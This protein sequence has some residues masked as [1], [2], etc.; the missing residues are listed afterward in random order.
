MY[1]TR[2]EKNE[3][4]VYYREID[5][6]SENRL[7]LTHAYRHN[8]YKTKMHSHQFYEINI[9]SYGEGRHYI[10]DSS[11]PTSVGD[12]F[13]LPPEIF[14][15]YHT[16]GTLDISHLILREEFITRYRDELEAM[17][18]F[19]LLFDIEPRLRRSVSYGCN[20]RIEPQI[21]ERVGDTF[22][23]IV[24]AEGS[25][26]YSYANVLTLSLIGL[27]CE[28]LQRNI[29]QNA[30]PTETGDLLRVMSYVRDNLDQK[31]TLDNLAAIANMSKSTLNR[32]FQR[33]L[34]ISPMQYV[35]HCRLSKA[36]RLVSEGHHTRTEIAIACGFYDVAHMN[37]Y[38]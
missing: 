4:T 11:I 3:S 15:G 20:L 7:H 6:F 37:K 27:M 16:N 1:P 8:D 38:L 18:C 32:H 24:R 29:E 10:G 31:L 13:V 17:P 12:V 28:L 33:A 36:K 25:G 2:L 34:R 21:M 30:F 23:D 14:H 35:T 26:N 19:S 9:I 5:C 22:E